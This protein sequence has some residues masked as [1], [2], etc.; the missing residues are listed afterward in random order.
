ML[1]P[2]IYRAALVPVVLAVIVTAFSLRDLPRPI[3]TTFAP[4]AFQGV[5]AF[6]ELRDLAGKYPDRRPGSVDD[7]RLAA[8][9]AQELRTLGPRHGPRPFVV[10][11][12]SIDADTIDGS[13][14][15]QTVIATR[16]G[17]PAPGIVLVAHRDAA[18]HRAEA[19]LSGT[20]G[21]LEIARVVA[22]GGLHRPVTLVSTSGGS[23]GDEG[24]ADAAAHVP[25]SVDAVLVLGNLA[26]T[27]SRRPFV[28][29]Y[30]NGGGI[31]PLRLRR[32]VDDAVRQEV[33]SDPGAPHAPTQWARLALPVTVGEQGEFGR[34]GMAAVLLSASGERPPAAG[35]PTSR[36]R[37]EGFG[38]AAL[39][40]LYAL[41]NGPDIATGPRAELVVRRKLLP[42]WAV[43]VI[44]GALLLGPVLLA[45]DGLARVRR[46]REPVARW[47]GWVVAGA[48]PFVLAAAFTAVLGATGLLR[49]A[50]SGAIPAENLRVDGPARIA[51]L[52]VVLVFVLGWIA[53]RPAAQGALRAHGWPDGPGAGAAA[54]VVLSALAAALWIANPFAAV[55][56]VP[57]L[58]LWLPLLTP[59]IRLRRGVSWGLFVLGLLPLAALALLDAVSLG[60]GPQAFAWFSLLRVAGGEVGFLSWVVWGLVASSALAVAVIGLRSP[61]DVPVLQEVTVRGPVTYA[62]PGSLGG[63]ESALRR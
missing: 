21:L 22:D 11:V 53:L 10:S 20:A 40:T 61:P 32:T 54:L 1:D 19:E 49:T 46:R 2:R 5:R 27:S 28:V 38:R 14:R 6:N 30:S 42:S 25:G 43:R 63:T 52:S 37:L 8:R 44:V 4:D 48:L 12:R 45:V 18:G 13:R 29:G 39:R 34:R 31:A 57:A 56:L 47:M 33:G 35:T 58:H 17:G 15:I 26:G 59:E 9:V 62:G 3:R 55:L 7:D 41:D 16:A 24:A 50:P 51:L 36:A 60:L 23:G